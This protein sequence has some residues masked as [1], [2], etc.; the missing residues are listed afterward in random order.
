MGMLLFAHILSK[1]SALPGD[2]SGYIAGFSAGSAALAPMAGITD[3]GM[4]RLAER[5]GAS[6]TVSEMVA[7][8]FYSAG[9]PANRMRAN[10]A[11]I[12]SNI[13]QIAGCSGES[14]ALAARIAQDQGATAID[15][16]MGCPAKKVTGGLAGSALM[17]NLDHAV[18]LIAA[19]VAA[20]SIPVTVKMRLGW[21]ETC[22][23]APGLARRAEAEGVAMVTVHG[24]TRCQFYNGRADWAAIRAV[25]DAVRIPVIANGDCGSL[26]D[27]R[28]M[29]DQSGA[30]GVMIG[31][32]AL[33]RP[34]LVGDIAH[35]LA[36]GQLRAPLPW[37]VRLE[38]ALEHYDTLL[39][40]HGRDKGV[41]HARK[42]LA[43]YAAHAGDGSA[44]TLAQRLVTSDDPAAVRAMLTTIF[45]AHAGGADANGETDDRNGSSHLEKA[46]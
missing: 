10:G 6:Y 40:I 37:N 29:L 33:G 44:S 11:G 39:S 7:S 32:A 21:D 24:R 4:R 43:A 17:R 9:D 19:T 46:A 8:S 18:S 35:G 1:T 36:T 41:R 15:I 26:G 23:N 3:L 31:R 34:W 38:A 28:T 27:A 13:V 45:D 16:N 25:K 20:V 12:A 2:A 22:L 42:H 14:L 30:D 5:F